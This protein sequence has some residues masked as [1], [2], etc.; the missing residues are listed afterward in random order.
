MTGCCSLLIPLPPLPIDK[1]KIRHLCS[2]LSP[3]AYPELKQ[4]SGS[5]VDRYPTKRSLC[6]ALDIDD[7]EIKDDIE[8]YFPLVDD[9][10]IETSHIRAELLRDF[11]L[12]T[13]R[14]G[15]DDARYNWHDITLPTSPSLLPNEDASHINYITVDR[16]ARQKARN[17]IRDTYGEDVFLSQEGF[18]NEFLKEF[19][20]FLFSNW[21]SYLTPLI[22][23]TIGKIYESHVPLTRAVIESMQ[24]EILDTIRKGNSTQENPA[25]Y[26]LIQVLIILLS[27]VPSRTMTANNSGVWLEK[28]GDYKSEFQS[29]DDRKR[30]AKLT[31]RRSFENLQNVLAER[32]IS[33]GMDTSLLKEGF[34]CS[35]VFFETVFWL[36]Q[37]RVA[38]PE[39]I[40]KAFLEDKNWKLG[41]CVPS[42][43]FNIA[44]TELTGPKD[45]DSLQDTLEGDP[46]T[47][48][49]IA[50]DFK[51]S[52]E[53]RKEQWK[54]F[55]KNEG[56]L[57]QAKKNMFQELNPSKLSKLYQGPKKAE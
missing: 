6:R 38:I 24:K 52:D 23:S 53:S 49:R 27:A 7:S 10:N 14:G 1:G 54:S 41:L 5:L 11:L 31:L 48:I 18:D 15:A 45:L 34:W 25:Q 17:Y 56:N 12:L 4:L 9:N 55:K 42:I 44:M 47:G 51:R 39:K 35:P 57:E 3:K 43:A 26:T 37:K 36:T 8:F 32:G 28:R 13:L 40:M 2:T 50:D 20:T 46:L 22:L 29:D 30:L 16:E 19:T 33:K 21:S